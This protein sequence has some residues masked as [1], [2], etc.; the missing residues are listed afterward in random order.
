MPRR[1]YGEGTVY[2]FRAGWRAQ[3]R[4]DGVRIGASG[5]T[6]Q[7][8]RKNLRAR[9]KAHKARQEWEAAGLT[10]LTVTEYLEGWINDLRDTQA[11]RPRTWR[12]YESI[13]RVY[14]EP[15]LGHLSLANLTADDV[16]GLFRTAML[17][18]LTATSQH[19]VHAVLRA[20]L[21]NALRGGVI[22]R[23]V[24]ALVKPPAMIHR[25]KVILDGA[26]A[27]R[28][29]GAARGERLGAAVILGVATGMREGEILG[30]RRRDVLLDRRQLRIERT[31]NVD[32]DGR[33]D[34]GTPKTE[35]ARRTV[36]LP[37]AAVD[38]LA[39]HLA[40][41]PGTEPTRLLFP[42]PTGGI[43]PGPGF[44]RRHFHPILDKAGLDPMPFHDLRHSAG[45][46]LK[47][48]GVD[49]VTISRILGHASP[50]ITAKFYGHVTPRLLAGATAK[51]DE[52]LGD[53]GPASGT[54]LGTQ[55]AA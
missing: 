21:A 27:R 55:P 40:T 7:E 3:A 23:N 49:E 42:S 41:M 31:G 54:Q 44:L 5:A 43:L 9:V 10:L 48:M 22:D 4:I 16:T 33:P 8:A 37:V 19:H 51:M 18:R 36:E 12:R 20:A 29:I 47:E 45:T 30:L 32:Y 24:A 46:I 38:A 50:A 13:V 26:K 14:L 25:D 28:L 35:H 39:E 34:L 52:A 15:L 17:R 1:T 2:P 6:P 53:G 11:V